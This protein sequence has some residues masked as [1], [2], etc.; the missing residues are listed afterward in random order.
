[1]S[2]TED[3]SETRRTGGKR[4]YAVRTLEIVGISVAL[5]WGSVSLYNLWFNVPTPVCIVDES[6]RSVRSAPA[7]GPLENAPAAARDETAEARIWLPA[8][9]SD[10]R[11]L[12]DGKV[13]LIIKR[14]PSVVT[15][16]VTGAGIPH[17]LLLMKDGKTIAETNF[18]ITGKQ[19][20]NLTPIAN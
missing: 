9:Y 19:T 13:P 4:F 5:V 7:A 10:V 17:T 20:L 14:T 15:I 11:I 3:S 2:K 6:G 1:M 12:L 8:Q 16:Q 18:S